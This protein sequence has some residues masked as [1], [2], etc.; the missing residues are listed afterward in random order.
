MGLR[1]EQRRSD[2]LLVGGGGGGAALEQ[3]RHRVRRAREHGQVE[4]R[5]AAAVG[6]LDGG[7]PVGTCEDLAQELR[8]GKEAR[9]VRERE[10]ERLLAQRLAR[11]LRVKLRLRMSA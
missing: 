8:L 7:Q 5:A 2:R 4:G 1:G 3:R 10:A 9:Q 6:R 11:L